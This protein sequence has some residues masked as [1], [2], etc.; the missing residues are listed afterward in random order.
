[1]YKEGKN[2]HISEVQ[3]ISLTAYN[4]DSDYSAKHSDQWNTSISI[5]T[6]PN[7]SYYNF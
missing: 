4:W 6:F 1:M 2:L 5:S 3:D 7:Q